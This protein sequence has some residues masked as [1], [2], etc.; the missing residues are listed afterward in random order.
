[1]GDPKHPEGIAH[2][3]IDEAAAVVASELS[4]SSMI[5]V[6]RWTMGSSFTTMPALLATRVSTT[7]ADWNNRGVWIHLFGPFVPDLCVCCFQ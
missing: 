2:P 1:M 4:H 3:V 7:Q 6:V 5:S